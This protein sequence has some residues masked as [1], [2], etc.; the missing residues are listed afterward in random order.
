MALL[1]YIMLLYP[2]GTVPG[3]H[4]RI[5]GWI[6]TALVGVVMLVHM[7]QPGPLD[8]EIPKLPANPLGVG[9]VGGVSDRLASIANALAVSLLLATAAS[10]VVR[11]RRSRGDERQQLKWMALAVV[12]LTLASVAPSLVGLGTSSSILFALAIGQLPIALGIAMFK[13]RL[14]AVDRLLVAV[15]TLVVAA[16]FL[17]LR[18]R[19]QT[20]VDRRFYRRRYDAQQTLEAFSAR[21]RQHVELETIG[22]GLLG[23]IDDTMEPTHVRLLLRQRS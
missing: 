22:G 5:V 17:P 8:A 4:W 12:I 19:I 18:R 15:S 10:V 11:F 6:L 13:Y 21:L 1:G 16:L 2:T 20:F 9:A 23:V 3:R 14:Y 7:T